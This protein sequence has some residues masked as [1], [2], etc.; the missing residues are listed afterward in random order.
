M[1]LDVLGSGGEIY[2]GICG[3]EDAVGTARESGHRPSCSRIRRGWV[4][5]SVEQ[6]WHA[7]T[8]ANADPDSTCARAD[9]I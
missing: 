9:A 5:W 4:K 1:K 7:H 2:S 8:L 3:I 6:V